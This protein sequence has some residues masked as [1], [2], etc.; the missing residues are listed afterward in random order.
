MGN[1]VQ[2]IPRRELDAVG[3]LAEFIRLC[4]EDLTIFGS[5][6]DWKSNAWDI[7]DDVV[8]RGRKGRDALVFSN[9]DTAG[10]R[11]EVTPMAMPFLDFAKA[12]MRYQ[13]LMRSTNDF[14]K[15]LAALRALEKILIDRSFDG[16]PRVEMTNSEILNTAAKLIKQ[17]APG[18]AYQMGNQLEILGSFLV[19]H[20]LT[21]VSF[22]WRNPNS[23]PL[24]T[25]IRIGTESEKKRSEK[26]PSAEAIDALIEAYRKA[27]E[28]RDVISTSIA[29]LLVCAPDRI[30]EV[31]R[32]PIN[33]EHK[34]KYNGVGAYGLRWW[35]SK[36]AEPMIKWI[37][38]TMQDIAKGAIKKLKKHSNEAREIALWYEKNPGK[39]FLPKGCEHLRKMK[40]ITTAEIIKIIGLSSRATANAWT[41]T[42]GIEP[43]EKKRLPLQYRFED[44]EKAIIGMLPNGFPIYDQETGLK[45]S[46]ALIIVPKNL[47]HEERGTYRCMFE[48]IGTDDINDELGSGEK[49][50]KSSIFSRLGIKDANGNSFKITSH[51]F[52]H[53]LNT[54]AQ[55]AGLSQLH[56]AK[57]SGRKDIRQNAAYDHVTGNELIAKAHELSNG[58]L[59]GPIADFVMHAPM[60]R[61]EFLKLAFPTAHVTE[62]G[63]CVHDWTMMPCE[64]YRDCLL[65]TEHLCVKGNLRTEGLKTK[66]TETE[67][68]LRRAKIATDEGYF[69]ADRWVDHHKRILDVL[70]GHKEI[71]NDP[72]IPDD[73][74][75]QLSGIR[76]HSP[77]FQA[78]EDRMML[79][80]PDA[81]A[82][83]LVMER[84][85]SLENKGQSAALPYM[86]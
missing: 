78:I 80:D 45:Y 10:T 13:Q 76:E 11:K 7:S 71:L 86:A 17:N 43:I 49:H 8:K 51:Q 79:D 84:L 62:Y 5:G 33:C 63:Y 75:Y 30:N 61:E 40:L 44:V 82:L 47:F 81:A 4:R 3:N 58:K 85:T 59:F 31:F 67:E 55:N 28:P 68:L 35:P 20:R 52:R 32:L 54:I 27:T 19:E 50:K 73:S 46:E 38:E 64:K 15:R 56:I 22:T 36:G 57:W 29:S 25:N 83:R 26:L 66:L 16:V 9:F 72:T 69:G 6:L 53:W 12:Y 65:C 1:I 2:F 14:G 60:S 39:L 41:I 24:D 34:A 18:S 74:V 42:N 77:V 37:I 70:R 21:S 48:T 23:K